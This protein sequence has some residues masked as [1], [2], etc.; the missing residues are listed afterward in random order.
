M[1]VQLARRAGPACPL[2]AKQQPGHSVVARFPQFSISFSVSVIIC[3]TI[4]GL[5]VPRIVLMV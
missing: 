2:T 4:A 1:P 5:P 3:L